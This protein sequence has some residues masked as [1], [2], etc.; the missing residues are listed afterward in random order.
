MEKITSADGTALAFERTGSGPPLVLVYGNGDIYKYWEQGGVRPAFAEHCT[1]YAIERRGRGESGDVAAYELE[2]EVE[3]VVAVVDSISE[4][5]T[6]LGNSGGAISSLEAALRTDKLRKLILYEP[7]IYLGDSKLYSEMENLLDR[8]E[9]GQA[10]V[11]F[12]RGI[13]GLTPEE[14]DAARSAPFWQDMVNAAHTLPRELQGI[15]DYEFDASRFAG[16]TT[17]TLLLSGSES[18]PFLKDGVEAV[19]EALPNSRITIFGG[20]G[21][22][23]MLTAQDRFIEEVLTFIRESIDR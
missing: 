15:A 8:G 20:E 14:I 22:D 13:A 12:L 23:A 6:L 21:H 18:A 9:N 5:V 3:D 7:P 19:N 17:P 16:M 2:R 10:L 11:L 4:P 1:V